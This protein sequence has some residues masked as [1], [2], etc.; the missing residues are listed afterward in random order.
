VGELFTEFLLMVFCLIFL[1]SQG[2][3]I[4]TFLLGAVPRRV[5]HRVDLAGRSGSL[6]TPPLPATR[7]RPDRET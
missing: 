2:N 4:W 7:N 6:A 5:R 3:K 1:L